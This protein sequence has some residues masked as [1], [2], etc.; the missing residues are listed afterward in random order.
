LVKGAYSAIF[1]VAGL[2]ALLGLA[3]L[4]VESELIQRIGG[5]W[6]ALLSG[7]VFGALGWSV[8][9]SHSRTALGVAIGLYVAD[10]LV[11]FG[12]ALADGSQPGVGG[13]FVRIALLT[14]MV[15]G[16]KAISQIREPSTRR[17]PSSVFP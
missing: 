13:I 17:A 4:F 7:C 8:W 16:F 15:R 3:G 10:A 9:K 5:G 6:P 12:A 11:T 2:S 1:F 14:I